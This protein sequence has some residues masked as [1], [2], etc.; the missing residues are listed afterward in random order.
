M[1]FCDMTPDQRRA[2]IAVWNAHG[3]NTGPMLRTMSN[4][5]LADIAKRTAAIEKSKCQAQLLG[6]EPTE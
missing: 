4:E 3:W 1:K 6:A 2:F 5:R